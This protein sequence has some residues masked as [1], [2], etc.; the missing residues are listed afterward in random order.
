MLHDPFLRIINNMDNSTFILFMLSFVS[1]TALARKD[2]KKLF[3]MLEESN[4]T[5]FQMKDAMDV[6]FK[7][8][9]LNMDSVLKSHVLYKKP[10]LKTF[11][12]ETNQ[13][14]VEVDIHCCQKKAAEKQSCQRRLV[15][16]DV[17]IIIEE[18]VSDPE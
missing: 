12:T 18:I 8:L 4:K 11:R 7:E 10:S 2:S 6:S 14:I 9:Q 1:M 13:T 5:V 15:P 17:I 3:T 16:N